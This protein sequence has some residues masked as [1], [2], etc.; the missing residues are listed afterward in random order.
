MEIRVNYA[1]VIALAISPPP[2]IAGTINRSR[3]A[4][5]L[6]LD[7]HHPAAARRRSGGKD[8]GQDS[9]PARA[10]HFARHDERDRR[11]RDDSDHARPC[12][13]VTIARA[14]VPYRAAPRATSNAL[15]AGAA[16]Q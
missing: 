15:D 7:A 13:V 16:A 2:A 3:A 14:I 6:G 12:Q 4:I 9:L 1:L 8:H 5:D 11:P 10:V